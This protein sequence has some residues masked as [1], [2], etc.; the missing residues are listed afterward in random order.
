MGGGKSSSWGGGGGGG[1]NPLDTK[2]LIS[3]R[4][5]KQTTVDQMLTVLR[6]VQNQYGVNMDTEIGIFPSGSN[7]MGYFDPETG[8]I[9]MNNSYFDSTRLDGVY[10]RTVQSGYHPSRG[11]KSG[12]EA[13]ASHEAGHKINYVA[14]D[15]AGMSADKLA[16]KVINDSAK[17]LG[18]KNTANMANKISKYAT[19]NYKEAIAE[20]FADVYCNSGKAKKESRTIVDEL[21]KYIR[22]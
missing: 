2:D 9:G 18:Y 10:D 19:E 3:A 5:G 6:D 8:N 15:R 17:K 14:S 21:N 7:V 13:V 12:M 11:D 22:P 16:E 4:E 20:A 1:G